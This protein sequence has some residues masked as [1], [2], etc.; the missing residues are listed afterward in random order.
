MTGHRS[1]L[2]ANRLPRCVNL[3]WS[4]QHLHLVLALQI[5]VLMKIQTQIQL[6]QAQ[7]LTDPYT[8][9]LWKGFCAVASGADHSTLADVFL[10]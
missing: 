3:H 10:Y 7:N 2:S 8:F 6:S 5:L 9:G 4:V 1:M